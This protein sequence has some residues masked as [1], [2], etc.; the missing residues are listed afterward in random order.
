MSPKKKKPSTKNKH[1]EQD[2]NRKSNP[3]GGM[4]QARRAVSDFLRAGRRN[5]ARAAAA[6]SGG[7]SDFDLADRIRRMS[8]ED[9]DAAVAGGKLTPEQIRRAG[10]YE[11]DTYM[12]DVWSEG[13]HDGEQEP[14]YDEFIANPQKYGVTYTDEDAANDPDMDMYPVNWG[15]YRSTI[16]KK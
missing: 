6:K 11:F 5:E 7:E 1:M 12:G 14:T 13:D 8:N 16:R 3:F 4:R 9:F 2:K 15:R 10:E